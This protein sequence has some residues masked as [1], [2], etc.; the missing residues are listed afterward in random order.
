MPP[1]QQIPLTGNDEK[2]PIE[3]WTGKL[4]TDYKSLHIF[5]CPVYFH[6]EQRKLDSRAKKAV[7]M[8]FITGVKGYRLWCPDLKEI[9]L[10]RYVTFDES[11]MF[12][13]SNQKVTFE[14]GMEREIS[15]QLE[16]EASMASIKA[17]KLNDSPTVDPN[18]EES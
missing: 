13:Q 11:A 5:G 16:F 2:T 14:G 12:K 3:V 4:A 1:H 17:V 9:V 7:F 18:G 10:S 8:G 6:V 15:Q